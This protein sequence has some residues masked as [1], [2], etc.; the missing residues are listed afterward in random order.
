MTERTPEKVKVCSLCGLPKPLSEFHRRRHTAKNG[1]RSAC[2]ACTAAV[3]KQAPRKPLTEEDRLKAR[4]RAQTQYAVERG[5]LI[6]TPCS[7]CGDPESE[8]HHLSYD[9]PDSYFHVVWMCKL[10]HSAEHGQSFWV[11][12]RELFPS[13]GRET[14]AK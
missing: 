13:F 12:Q 3:K 2:K 5:E 14:K 9:R 6:P 11:R 4:V 1:Y 7:V 10:H 8:A